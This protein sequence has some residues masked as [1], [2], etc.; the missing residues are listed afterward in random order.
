LAGILPEA[1]RDRGLFAFNPPYGR[2]MQGEGGDVLRLYRDLGRA[3]KLFDGW[4]AAVI[5]ANEGFKRAFNARPAT[6]K[7]TSVAG[8]PAEFLV[9]DLGRRQSG[10]KRSS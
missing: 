5:V 7:P 4:R 1:P 8:L 9:F 6:V 2:R 3:L 10:G